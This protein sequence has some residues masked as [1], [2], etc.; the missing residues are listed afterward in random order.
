MDIAK[1]INNKVI[2]DYAYEKL[3]LLYKETNNHKLALE[4]YVK[5]IT[6]KDSLDK[7]RNNKD[8]VNVEINYK[9]KEKENSNQLLYTTNEIQKL[10]IKNQ[11]IL[12]VLGLGLLVIASLMIYIL[13][14][15]ININ[16]KAKERLQ[17]FNKS[18]EDLVVQRS[19]ELKVS[20]LRF[21]KIFEKVTSV[22]VFGF[23]IKHEIVYWNK[24]NENFFGYTEKE[25]IGKKI[26]ELIIPPKDILKVKSTL[27]SWFKDDIELLSNEVEFLRKNNSI[28]PVFSNRVIVENAKGEKEIYTINIDMTELKHKTEQIR[29]LSAVVEQ[30]ANSVI[31][32]DTSGIIEYA[33]S[34]VYTITGYTVEEILC[35]NLKDLNYWEEDD[36]LMFADILKTIINDGVWKGEARRL[37][38]DGT[39]IWEYVVIYPLKDA[40]NEIINLIYISEDITSQ[41]E[42][43]K[44]LRQSEK[45]MAI[46]TLANGIA[47]DFNNILYGMINYTSIVKDEILNLELKEY[48]DKV[49]Q[50]GYRAKELINQILLFS[51]QTEEIMDELNLSQ[52]VMDSIKFITPIIAS[53]IKIKTNID[54][55]PPI[56]GN[57]ISINQI[58]INLATNSSY[59]MEQNGIIEITTDT[60]VVDSINYARILFKDD[61]VGIS[62]DIKQRIFD[63]FFTTKK[64]GDGT[65]LGLSTVN[66]I[67][68]R[69]KG[70]INVVSEQGKGCTFEL[71][72]PTIN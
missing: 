48:L 62:D 16:K 57:T 20:E 35:K 39:N 50:S 42:I 37:R 52:I 13:R 29:K 5:Y 59:A 60:V 56:L 43:E 1:E 63:P 71:L 36:K 38:K 61:G 9:L 14:N 70:K 21:N 23:N 64:F 54:Q 69:L 6:L 34:I 72:F 65:G 7:E 66:G 67:V 45:I 49:M 46:G 68:R 33:N 22:A 19:N 47:H 31:I 12:L 8:I 18:L 3:Y 55:T 10:R 26:E 11:N 4:S 27:D 51:R 40:N 44:E 25:A 53:S 41:K 30:S 2:I 17:E 32:F 24:A 15:R 28:I 58:L